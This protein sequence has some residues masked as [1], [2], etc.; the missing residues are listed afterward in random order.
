M[1]VTVTDFSVKSSDNIH[2]L[3][4]KVYLPEGKPKGHFQIV[5]GMTEHI[6][7]Y[8][9][10]MQKM[11][12]NGYICFGFDNLGHGNTA[13]DDAELGFIAEKDGYKYMVL[14]VIEFYRAV[15]DKYP[16]DRYVLM[17]H[18]MG[19]FIVRLVAEQFGD[20]I[21]SLIICGTAGPNPAA[22]P[23]L[24][25]AT[26]TEKLKGGRY[27][28]KL[29]DTLAFGAYNR[30]FE[31]ISK[32][33]WLTNDRNIIEIYENDKFC[34]FKFKISAMRDLLKLIIFCNRKKWFAK[35]NKDLPIL[36]ISGDM[37]PV[38]N[39][40]KGVT[41]VFKALRTSGCKDVNLYLYENCR[42]EILNDTCK[43]EVSNDILDFLK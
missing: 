9:D 41:K 26:I 24:L 29:V 38:G 5:H 35:I 42:H 40:G 4:G 11:A 36:L 33:D 8:D 23:G 12:S 27:C 37:D 28:S 13:R 16:A 3:K 19:S 15:K 10:F 20:L 43:E 1:T 2:T 22:I 39:Y 7:R 21:D 32:Y 6:K 17:G 31:G 25:I 14:D 30:R 18:S 34:T